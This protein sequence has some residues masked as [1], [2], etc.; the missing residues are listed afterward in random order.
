MGTPV[1]PSVIMK[2]CDRYESG[3][4]KQLDSSSDIV[5]TINA[6]EP[7]DADEIP[8]DHHCTEAEF[9]EMNDL[10]TGIDP[11][12]SNH[13]LDGIPHQL[14]KPKDIEHSETPILNQEDGHSKQNNQ[15]IPSQSQQDSDHTNSNI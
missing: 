2:D 6:D 1:K 8:N 12:H 9:V 13:N 15:E 11:F 5:V 10:E 4:N 14:A 3:Q 7:I